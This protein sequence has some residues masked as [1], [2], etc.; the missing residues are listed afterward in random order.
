MNS[1]KN[2]LMFLRAKGGGELL[3]PFQAVTYDKLEYCNSNIR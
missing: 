2:F 3:A 1:G